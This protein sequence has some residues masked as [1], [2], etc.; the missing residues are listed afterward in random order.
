VNDKD[1][2]LRARYAALRHEQERL[3]PAYATIVGRRNSP[4]RVNRLRLGLVAGAMAIVCAVVV[5]RVSQSPIDDGAIRIDAMQGAALVAAWKSPTDFLLESSQREL[6]H[7]GPGIGES[8]IPD[9]LFAPPAAG[10]VKSNFIQEK[11]S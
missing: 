1:G 5:I 10:G 4:Q 8:A 2:E 3:V 9:N 11:T 6:M 7:S